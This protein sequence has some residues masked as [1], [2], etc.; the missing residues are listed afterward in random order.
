MVES[1]N[2]AGYGIIAL[3][4]FAL[5]ITGYA[6][7][8][9]VHNET[10]QIYEKHSSVYA[11]EEVIATFGNR[12]RTIWLDNT[13]A[14][15]FDPSNFTAAISSDMEPYTYPKG[16]VIGYGYDI[17]GAI[18]VLYYQEWPVNQTLINTIYSHISSKGK[19]YG[20]E[21]IP[22]RFI[23]VDRLEQRGANDTLSLQNSTRT[24]PT[25]NPVGIIKATPTVCP[26]LGNTS[27]WIHLNQVADHIV[28]EKFALRGTTNLKP[29][30]LLTVS[31]YQ[32]PVSPTK[33]YSSE[34]TEV[35]GHTLVKEGNCTANTWSFSE[36]LTTLRPCLYSI[37]VTAENATIGANLVQFNIIDTDNADRPA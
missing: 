34:F 19:D 14:A 5:L 29:G 18:V 10:S 30:E 32:T 28:G 36:N 22:C 15:S 16:P 20:F 23:S 24:S 8:A 21:S 3:L 11:K 7:T 33:K 13:H 2:N 9:P 37:Y 6:I 4:I 26:P 31:V 35:Q 17:S 12:N 27:P 1:M 25:I